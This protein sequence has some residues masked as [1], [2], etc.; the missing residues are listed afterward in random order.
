MP[1][2]TSSRWEVPTSR[3]KER[4]A[5]SPT[6]NGPAWWD[7]IGFELAVGTGEFR[8]SDVALKEGIPTAWLEARRLGCPGTSS[9]GRLVS[10]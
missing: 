2:T 10:S 4:L 6:G 8:Q 1:M 5:A 9:D 7:C 3:F